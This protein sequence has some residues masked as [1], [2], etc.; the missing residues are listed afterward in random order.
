MAGR[1]LRESHGAEFPG[2]MKNFKNFIEKIDEN[3]KTFMQVFKSS[4]EFLLKF[5]QKYATN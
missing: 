3:L 5:D 1:R 4:T 2:S